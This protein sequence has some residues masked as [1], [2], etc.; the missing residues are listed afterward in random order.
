VKVIHRLR[1]LHRLEPLGSYP[2]IHLRNLR[3]LRILPFHQAMTNW[4]TSFTA[5]RPRRSR[6]WRKRRSRDGKMKLIHRLRRLHRLEPLGSYSSFHLR[7]LY[8]KP[9]TTCFPDKQIVNRFMDAD[10]TA[11]S[12]GAHEWVYPFSILN[13]IR[14]HRRLSAVP[15]LFF[16][17]VHQCLS[18]VSRSLWLRPK[19][20]LWF[21]VPFSV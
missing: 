10:S 3:N 9:V 14:V 19:A 18:V 4:C 12:R 2:I 13:F 17:R 21:Q 7:N 15:H 8:Y 5:C 6:S 1:R 11:D 16:I 20:T